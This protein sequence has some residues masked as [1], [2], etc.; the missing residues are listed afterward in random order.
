[1]LKA[2]Q[3]APDE[4][5]RQLGVIFENLEEH[6]EEKSEDSSFIYDKIVD[7]LDELD[8][9]DFFGTEGWRHNFGLGD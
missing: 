1:M 8:E 4:V 6:I 3:L 9:E 2:G 7:L 5:D